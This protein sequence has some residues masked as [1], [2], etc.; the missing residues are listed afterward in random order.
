MTRYSNQE[1]DIHLHMPS[2][3]FSRMKKCRYQTR[4]D[5]RKNL[6]RSF[7]NGVRSG[8]TKNSVLVTLPPDIR[9][10]DPIGALTEVY[11]SPNTFQIELVLQLRD[12]GYA[13]RGMSTGI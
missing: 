11:S 8:I 6:V 9:I 3:H 2:L 7:K 1:G 12:C 13:T 10:K 4:C 5:L